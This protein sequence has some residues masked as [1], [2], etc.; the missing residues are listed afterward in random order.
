MA[1]GF[2]GECRV[3]NLLEF[4][5]FLNEA[6]SSYRRVAGSHRVHGYRYNALLRTTSRIGRPRSALAL[7]F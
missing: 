1:I 5:S 7:R 4:D 3:S 2:F 6:R